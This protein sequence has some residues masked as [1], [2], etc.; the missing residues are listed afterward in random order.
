MNFH[1]FMK[2]MNSKG[3]VSDSHLSY[4]LKHT[5]TDGKNLPDTFEV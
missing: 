2:L 4:I 1:E 3:Y 5:D